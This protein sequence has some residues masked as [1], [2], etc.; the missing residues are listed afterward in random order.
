MTATT[1]AD[2][3]RYWTPTTSDLVN[4]EAVAEHYWASAAA[5][6]R[7]W[8]VAALKLLG[9]DVHRVLDLGCQC[10]P[11]L[12]VLH[13]HDSTLQLIGL[14]CNPHALA[15]GRQWLPEA[16]FL[17]GA[18]PDAIARWGGSVDVVLSTYCL[19]YQSPDTILDTLR[20]CLRLALK[21]VVLVEPMPNPNPEKIVVTG[22]DYVEWRH[23]Y[24]TLIA[25]LVAETEVPRNIRWEPMPRYDTLSGVLIITPVEAA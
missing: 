17:E 12:R 18:I 9:T 6:H 25:E 8:I 4:V 13:D 24:P 22:S 2:T 19:A 10:G 14:D 5:P 3:Q 21:A 11:N 16:E 7:A 15:F 20:H 23:P 1:T